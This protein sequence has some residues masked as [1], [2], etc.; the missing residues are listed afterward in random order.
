[1]AYANGLVLLFFSGASDLVFQL[2]W[3]K[4]L[5]LIVGID[6]YAITVAISAFFIGLAGGGAV[7]GRMADE[8]SRPLRLYAALEVATAVIGVCATMVLARAASPFATAE[9]WAG[10]LACRRAS[11]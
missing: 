11:S 1:M 4:Q 2:L 6:V 3:I 5:S 8:A 9:G 10:V 7:F